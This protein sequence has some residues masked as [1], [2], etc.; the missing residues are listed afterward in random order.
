MAEELVSL[1]ALRVVKKGHAFSKVDSAY[2][3]FEAAF[4]YEETPDQMCAI[5]DVIQDMEKKR[6][7]DRLVCGDVGYGKTEVAVRGAYK[8]VMDGKQVAVL[9]PTTVLAQQHYGNFLSRFREQP[10]EIQML[11]RFRSPKEQ[12]TILE[13]LGEG[14]V[15]ILIGTH[16][17][18]QKDVKF[19]DLGLLILDEEQRF[20]VRHKEALKRLRTEVDVLTLSATPIPRTLQMSLLGLRDMS[21]ISTPP[22]DRHAIETY[23]IPF[24]TEIIRRALAQE[25]ARGGQAFFVHN[26]VSDIEAIADKVKRIVPEARVTIGHG[27]MSERALERVMLEF[28]EGRHDILV[29]TTIIE[30]GMDIPNANTLLVNR[31]DRFGLAQLYQLRGRVGRSE[32]QAYA[33]LIAPDMDALSDDARKRLEALYEFTELGSGFRIARYD[34]EIRGAGNLLGTS[35]SGQIRAVGYDLYMDFLEKAIR[36]LKGEEVVEE[37]DPE[38]HFEM[39]ALLPN[40][41]IEDSTQRLSLYKRLATASDHAEV[42]QLRS[43]IR[44]RYGPLPQEA[45]TLI[46]LMQVKVRLRNLKIREARLAEEGLLLSFASHTAVSVGQILEWATREPERLRLFPDDRL[47]IRFTAAD[48]EEQ[49]RNIE[50]ILAWLERGSEKLKD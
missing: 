23:I 26:R 17:L 6:P 14:K 22:Q 39:P 33:Y 2:Q 10:V 44:D 35:Q 20:G 25:L 19:R 50:E 13:A 24:D 5:D 32:R 3:E 9:V 28:V 8:S 27:Q 45:R 43:E 49:M 12:R 1:Y 11:S 21:T 48:T 40:S 37:V 46:S 31:A 41:Y 30:S 7:M 15:D 47:L 16:R 4:P 36:E 42:E 18:L 34:M 38:I 29:C